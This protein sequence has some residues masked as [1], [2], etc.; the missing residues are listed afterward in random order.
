MS[1]ISELRKKVG[2]DPI[3]MPAACGFL[4]RGGKIGL[5][6]RA[7]NH[8]WG[9]SGG[10]MEFGETMEQTLSR[11]L[12]EELDIFPVKTTFIGIY[13]GESR[14]CFYP[15][16]DEAYCIVVAYLVED[17]IGKIKIDQTEVIKFGW[18]TP[19]KLPPES[20]L[21]LPDLDPLRDALNFIKTNR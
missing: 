14:H 6:L 20:E 11:E 4:Y 1:Y 13:A 5:Q 12:K 21:N 16:Q 2:H 3:F 9:S 18:F 15:N 19:E 8:K 17:F 7:D 10:G